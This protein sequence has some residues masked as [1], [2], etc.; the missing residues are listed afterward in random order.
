MNSSLSSTDALWS[1]VAFGLCGMAIN[2]ARAQQSTAS[3][4][5]QTWTLQGDIIPGSAVVKAPVGSAVF[6][7][8]PETVGSPF[9]G[10]STAGAFTLVSGP[11]GRFYADRVDDFNVWAR[12]EFSNPALAGAQPAADPDNDGQNNQFEWLSLTDPESASSRLRLDVSLLSGTQIRLTLEPYF[13]A[14]RS[15]S[16]LGSAS[17]GAFTVIDTDLGAAAGSPPR[18]T[19]DIQ[20]NAA[21]RLRFFKA[22]VAPQP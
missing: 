4:G 7:L 18:A 16:L 12:F 14:L 5:G 13:P 1:F 15:Y 8:V 17:L 21:E 19:Q 9:S 11:A 3:I 22:S 2:P 20:L 10:V 6:E